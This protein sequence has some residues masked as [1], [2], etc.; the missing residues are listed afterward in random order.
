[1]STDGTHHHRGTPADV[2]S[3]DSRRTPEPSA[4]T[5]P[6]A[7]PH[8]LHSPGTYFVTAGTLHK[9]R[10]INTPEK[11]DFV[12][13]AMLDSAKQF[14]W[15]LRAWAVLIN[16]Y[17]FVAISPEGTAQSLREWLKELHKTTATLL[18]QIDETPG[19]RVWFQFRDTHLTHQTSYLSRLRYTHSNP[20][21]HGLVKNARD[22]R[23]CSAAWFETNA[24]KSF[25][26]S[27][28]RFKIDK[29]NVWDDF[30][31]ETDTHQ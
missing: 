15:E 17:H 30:D 25:V 3:G 22:Y 9:Q 10:I 28:E 5:W 19:R 18:N 24:P 29:L 7:P 14:D 12:T 6:H 16:H 31:D 13:G 23:W 2:K 26:A 8:W 27:V 11:L 1:M 21:H 20:V 4:I